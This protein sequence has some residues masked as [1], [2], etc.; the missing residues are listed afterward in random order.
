MKPGNYVDAN[1]GTDLV[2]L[3]QIQPI[4]VDFWVPET[5]LFTLQQKQK[6]GKLKLI[7]YPD[8]AHKY[9]FNGELTLIDNQVNTGTGAVLL[10]GTLPNSD[11]ALWPGHFVDVRVILDEQKGTLLLPNEAV[12]VGQ[13]G[14]Y[15]YV[16]KED[17]TVE[18]RNVKIGQEYDDK[19]I[20]I[21]SGISAGEQ[22]VTQGQLSLLPGMKVAIQTATATK[23]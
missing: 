1:S 15:V 7:V 13:N 5:D 3:N 23:T 11:K 6:N 10:E 8:P 2:L 20:S 18:L 22:I 9:H 16:V 19:Y 4:L 17:S 12:M 14:H 21:Q